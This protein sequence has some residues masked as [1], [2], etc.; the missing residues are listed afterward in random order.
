VRKLDAAPRRGGVVITEGSSCGAVLGVG[1][2]CSTSAAPSGVVDDRPVARAV[3]G[4]LLEGLGERDSAALRPQ[5][6]WWCGRVPLASTAPGT[7][8]LAAWRFHGRG[9]AIT[10]TCGAVENALPVAAPGKHGGK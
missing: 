1:A 4:I 7:A 10:L 2:V 6:V 9:H 5:S 3:S 8:L